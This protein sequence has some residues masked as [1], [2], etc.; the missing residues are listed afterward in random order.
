MFRMAKDHRADAESASSG[1]GESG[2]GVHVRHSSLQSGA[3]EESDGQFSWCRM[4]QGRSVPARGQNAQDRPQLH[5]LRRLRRRVEVIYIAFGII[6]VAD[7]VEI[8]SFSAA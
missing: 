8:G 4:S 5:A 2:L 7:F 6:R 1:P 3:D